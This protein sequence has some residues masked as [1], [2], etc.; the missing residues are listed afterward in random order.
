M[1]EAS[2]TWRSSLPPLKRGVLNI[3][4]PKD[5]I[6][7]KEKQICDQAD[8]IISVVPEMENF[9]FE[10][11]NLDLRKSKVISNLEHLEF[12]STTRTIQYSP[13]GS[14]NVL[15]TGGFGFHRGIH[16]AII[17]MSFLKHTDIRLRLVGAGNKTLM[18]L[19]NNLIEKYSLAET[20]TFTDWVAADEV[21]AYI[22]AADVC[23][24]PHEKNAHTDNTIPHKLYQYMT[25]GRPVVV[26][27][28]S[29]LKRVVNEAKSGLVFEAGNPRSFADILQE[30]YN[31]RETLESYG[32]H[33]FDYV[34]NQGNSWNIEALKLR[35]IYGM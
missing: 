18:A 19:Y 14:F 31:N 5:K 8:L 16:T 32:R 25:C 11:H 6:S 1:P 29:P 22:N 9:L 23:I 2:V 21:P 7:R 30:M 12:N 24:V 3:I 26:S 13:K 33:G 20:V 27:D 35:E 17:A 28:C 15:Y 4:Q 34:H 10:K